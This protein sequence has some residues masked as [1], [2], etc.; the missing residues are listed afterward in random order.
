MRLASPQV[1]AALL[2]LIEK[3]GLAGRI[4]LWHTADVPALFAV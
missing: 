1:N 4:C 2:D 3:E